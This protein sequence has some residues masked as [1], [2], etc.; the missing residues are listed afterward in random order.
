M[1]IL[2]DPPRWPAHGTRFAHLASDTSLAELHDFARA[3]EV[4]HR[5][6]DH[7]HYDVPEARLADLVAA[8]AQPVEAR[9]LVGRLAASG[10][11]VRPQQRVPKPARAAAELARRWQQ[12]LPEEPRLGADLV[13]RWQEQHRRYHD[14]R[15]LV[16][17]LGALDQLYEGATP[18]PVALAAWFHDAVYRGEPGADEAA[19]AALARAELGAARVPVDLVSEVSRLVMLTVDHRAEPTDAAGQALV[20][21]DLSILGQVPGRYQMYVRGVR[22][23][24]PELNNYRFGLARLGVIRA[25]LTAETL[26]GSGL[27]QQL[28]LDRARH[29]LADEEIHWQGVVENQT[30]EER[31]PG[32]SAVGGK[33]WHGLPMYGLQPPPA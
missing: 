14:T 12:L 8:G 2:I 32:I 10:L 26:F 16:Q 6:F 5:A 20:D 31:S 18:T 25:L 22:L 21:A 28:W 33:R 15:H 19:S 11:R 17:M 7:D 29:N 3:N 23:E 30:P 4:P 13:S 27:G 9:E 24:H 1:A